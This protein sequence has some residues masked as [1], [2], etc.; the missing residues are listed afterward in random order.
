[1]T[2]AAGFLTDDNLVPH[3]RCKSKIDCHQD[4]AIIPDSTPIGARLLPALGHTELTSLAITILCPSDLALFK[5][6]D[7]NWMEVVQLRQS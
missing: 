7:R 1:M 3:E 2:R 4:A 5:Q 6:D